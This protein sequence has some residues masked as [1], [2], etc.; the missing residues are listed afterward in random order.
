MVRTES[1]AERILGRLIA[2]PSTQTSLFEADPAVQR[3]LRET[4][5]EIAGELRLEPRFEAMG[6]LYA[7]VGRSG[8]PRVLLFAYAMTHPANRRPGPFMY[9]SGVAPGAALPRLIREAAAEAGLGP[10]EER[11]SHGAID[12]GFFNHSD[13]EAVMF[14]PGAPETFHTDEES[15]AIDD[16]AAAARVYELAV[17]KQLSARRKQ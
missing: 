8:G 3:Y 17:R 5:A 7:S 12:A 13:T 4:V 15:V 10:V 6:N 9:P 2:A 11:W 14:G 16:V 1:A